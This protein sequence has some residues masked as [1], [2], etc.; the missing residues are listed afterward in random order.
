MKL[1]TPVAVVLAAVIVC[2]TALVITL[3]VVNQPSERDRLIS[4]S[5]AQA[6][7]RRE[8][9]EHRVWNSTASSW[10]SSLK[11]DPCD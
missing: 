3:V 7:C 10:E 1:S 8:N 6:E 4:R 2:V 5:R 9:P 11:N